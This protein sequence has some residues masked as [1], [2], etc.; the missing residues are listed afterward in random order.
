MVKFHSRITKDKMIRHIY[1]FLTL[2][3]LV[4]W[5]PVQA[6]KKAPKAKKVTVASRLVDNEGNP[7]PN[8]MI[9]VG[10]GALRTFSDEN[11]NFNFRTEAN[12]VLLIEALGHQSQWVDL[13]KG[14]P[15]TEIVLT[16]DLLFASYGDKV[17]LPLNIKSDKRSLTGAVSSV[18]GTELESYPDLVMANALQG[19][20]MGLTVRS[21]VNGLGANSPSLYVR[22][23]ARGGS[24]GIITVVD[25]IERSIDYLIAEEIESIEVLKDAT[26]KI[27]YGPRAA[28]GVLLVTTKNGRPNS[29]ILRAS[30]DYGT[31]MTTRM[32][33]YLNSFEY[34]TL[35]NEARTNDG[36]S[37]FYSEA[38]LAG[39]KNSAGPNDQ[40]YPDVDYYDYF[41][42]E[43]ASYQK[44]AFEYSGGND[45]NQYALILGYVGGDGIEK[46]GN[47]PNL[48]RFNLRG[49]LNF[50]IN[51]VLSAHV[52]AAGMVEKRKWGTINNAQAFT[53][54][55]THRPN[56]YPFIIS[57]PALQSEEEGN[58]EAIPPLGGSFIR[59]ANLYGQFMYGGFSEYET[60]YGQT[61]IGLNFKLDNLLKGLSAHAYYTI[62]NYQY[63]QNGKTEVPVSYAQRWF[64][65]PDGRDTV[66][67]YQVRVRSI[68]D[69]QVLQSQSFFNNN[70][71]TASV[72]YD[73]VFGNH[74]IY[75]NLSHFYYKNGN[76]TSLQDVENTNSTLNVKYSFRNK[77]YSEVTMAFMGSNKFTKDNRYGLFPAV[78]L[79]WVLS[80]E[81]FLKQNSSINFLKV[82]GSFGVLGYDRATSHYLFDNRW[83]TAGTM[84]FNERNGTGRTRA[85]LVSIGNPDLQW[86]KSREINVGVQGL[87]LNNRL[88]F[89]FNYFN[90]YRYDIIQSPSYRYPVTAGGLFSQVNQGENLNRGLEG[91]VNWSNALGE[92][93]Y[94]VGGN[95]IYAKNKVMKMNEVIYPDELQYTRETGQPSDAIFGYVSEGLFT[96]QPQ[97]DNHALQTLGRYGLG[98]IAYKDLNGDGFINSLDR[99]AIGNSYP[100]TTLG[101][102]VD[103][104]YKRFG[105][106]LLGTSEIGIDNLLTNNYYWNRSE[107]KYTEAVNDRWHA[108][109]NPG[110][111]YPALTTTS[112]SN[113][114]TN[115]TFWLEDGSFFRL[116]NVE[117]SYTLPGNALAR[118]YRFYARGS[119]IFVLSKNK[120][121]D[122]E[123]INAGVSNYPVFRTITGGVSVSF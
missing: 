72:A 107:D 37:P 54:L 96:S 114:F 77:I 49:N 95:F 34:A 76:T 57:D 75:T 42:N 71:W 103:I 7:V 10:E 69:N 36:L 52:G 94:T 85:Q 26:A 55:S 113:D 121:L 44:A 104:N 81:S 78:G 40:R 12:S 4:C 35:Y 58:E 122:P 98:S 45:L 18:S 82:K 56:E 53:A 70:G 123:I 32:P 48:E 41:L 73:Q 33:E 29:K 59:P 46:I 47:Q 112:G 51:E 90:E 3:A 88:Q 84:N 6:Q 50:T 100:R 120:D 83:N 89:E 14:L 93:K 28:N 64:Q 61:N 116:K 119:N 38:D 5:A 68:Q 101:V 65:T 27:L 19:R 115:S 22:G 92:V 99:Q 105:L 24:D 97:L 86:E 20:I 66:Q 80:E 111:K 39:Y 91:Q 23:L 21:T 9:T 15:E 30:V 62:D 2:F 1:I 67:Y 16:K 108:V 60:F 109:N 74:A 13:S 117:L 87:A 17:N 43:S 79:A 8:A 63:F 118:S 31:S 25:G 102:N 110:G 106:F 11:G